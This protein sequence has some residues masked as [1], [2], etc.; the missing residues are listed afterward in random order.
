MSA[1]AITRALSPA[2]LLARL[3]LVDGSGS[4][5]DADTVRQVAPQVAPAGPFGIPA[6]IAV[7]GTPMPPVR[8]TYTDSL[9]RI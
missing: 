3:Q 7:G 6:G 9:F 4:G 1:I 5:L 2:Q 8:R